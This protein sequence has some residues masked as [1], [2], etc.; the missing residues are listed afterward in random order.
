MSQQLKTYG[1][2]IHTHDRFQQN[3][4]YY[5][6]EFEIYVKNRNG[7]AIMQ[8]WHA[9]VVHFKE[10]DNLKHKFFW[11]FHLYG[12]VNSSHAKIWLAEERNKI[13]AKLAKEY[14]QNIYAPETKSIYGAI[15]KTEKWLV[16][17]YEMWPEF[18]L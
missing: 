16:K 18:G 3:H 7:S 12:F 15:D 10:F 11:D 2:V 9:N 5:P 13:F 6:G 17:Q 14:D 8:K 1:I 4:I